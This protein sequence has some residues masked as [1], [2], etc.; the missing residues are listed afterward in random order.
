MSLAGKILLDN[1][2]PIF[3]AIGA[4]FALARSMS[5][6]AETLSRVTLYI[7]SPCLVFTFLVENQ[8]RS[9]EVSGIV[10]TNLGVTA[11]SFL[12]GWVAARLLRLDRVTTISMMLV[13]MF[14]N[15]GN[16]GLSLTQLAF[17]DAALAR[18]V[19]YFVTTSVVVYT[20]GIYLA[21]SGRLSAGDAARRLFSL[22]PIYAVLLAFVAI[23]SG[24]PVPSPLM[25]PIRLLGEAAI[26]VMLI[27]LGVQMAQ[28][29]PVRELKTVLVASGLR[30]VAGPL[31]ALGLASVLGLSGATRQAAVLEASMPT[32]VL[33]I[34][35]A[36]EFDV[37]PELVTGVV[38][39]STLLSPLTLTALIAFLS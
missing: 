29:G 8:I 18:A 7:F 23:A 26:P 35:L 27:V 17:G 31:V 32:A 25:T 21:S 3:L 2:L 36:T 30:L 16:Y 34:V 38:V 1:I 14:T 20:L 4:G 11:S 28:V 19:I 13:L 15:G 39:V 33:T 37:R 10:L 12:L 22:P 6:R 5:V 9:G 24:K